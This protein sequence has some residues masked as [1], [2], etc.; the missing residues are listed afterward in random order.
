MTPSKCY[1]TPLSERTARC[2]T[3]PSR[4]SRGR[5]NERPRHPTTD[6][7]MD[8]QVHCSTY[9]ARCSIPASLKYSFKATAITLCSCALGRSSH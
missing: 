1:P 8:V 6:P 3:L 5:W 9:G 4:L 2:E 7:M